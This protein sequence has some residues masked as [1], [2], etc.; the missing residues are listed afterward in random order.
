L[1]QDEWLELNNKE[2]SNYPSVQTLD[3]MTCQENYV[4]MTQRCKQFLE[5]VYSTGSIKEREV[6]YS[7]TGVKGHGQQEKKLLWEVMDIFLGDCV[8][9]MN[10]SNRYLH[11]KLKHGTIS[12][13]E[14]QLTMKLHRTWLDKDSRINRVDDAAS[15]L[16]NG[17]HIF[18]IKS[19]LQR[20]GSKTWLVLAYR[21]TL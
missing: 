3:E 19:I 15:Q 13:L 1:A 2:F 11:R 17:V 10:D 12:A 18:T 8:L 4:G 14:K 6:D 5:T 9:P 7:G 20:I 16:F 21:T